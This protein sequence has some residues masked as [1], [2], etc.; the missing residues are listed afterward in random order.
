MLTRP[1]V[2]LFV[3]V[4]IVCFITNFDPSSNPHSRFVATTFFCRNADEPSLVDAVTSTNV[5]DGLVQK[6]DV[7]V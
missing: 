4:A 3:L 5:T 7:F 2:R 6:V 1:N